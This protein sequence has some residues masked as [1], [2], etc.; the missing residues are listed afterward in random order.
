MTRDRAGL[1]ISETIETPIGAVLLVEDD[2]GALCLAEFAD[3][4]ARI[5]QGMHRLRTVASPLRPGTISS[6]TRHAFDAYFGG[7][8]IALQ[9]VPVRFDGTPFQAS[10]WSALRDIPAG[11][12]LTY[13]AF[14]ERLGRSTASRAVGAANGAN[15]LSIIVPCHR[16]VGADG[17]LT[18]Y[19]G[20][21]ERKRRLLDHEARHRFGTPQSWNSATTLRLPSIKASATC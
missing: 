15:P 6:A 8:V 18:N 13:G 3:R 5:Q 20:G 10:V 14:A 7:D 1:F 21:M 2:A 19:G 12:V 17:S 4:P 9:K 11:Y 16:L